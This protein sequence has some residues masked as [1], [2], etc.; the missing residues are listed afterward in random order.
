MKA[1]F[2]S[3]I[4]CIGIFSI[5]SAEAQSSLK[6][7]SIKV[8]GNCGMCKKKIEAAAISAGASEANWNVK[9]KKLHVTYDASATGSQ[10]IQESIAKAGYDTESV[11]ATPESYDALHG[12]CKYERKDASASAKADDCCKDGKACS[13]HATKADC[14]KDGKACS[15]HAAKA[16]CC[17]DGK[18]CSHHAAKADCCKDGKECSHHAAKADCCKDGKECKDHTACKEKGCCAGQTCCKS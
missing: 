6:K 18:A 8:W 11:T 17:K 10:K 12:C 7:E 3:L 16:D 15:H 9:K 4:A 13:Q 14:C 5:Q 1:L 2:I